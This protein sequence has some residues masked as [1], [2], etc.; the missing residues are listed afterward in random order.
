M[1]VLLSKTLISHADQGSPDNKYLH[2]KSLSLKC[3]I[4]LAGIP[5]RS[6][7]LPVSSPAQGPENSEVTANFLT[8]F[9][10]LSGVSKSRTL[11]SSRSLLLISQQP[12]QDFP[13]GAFRYLIH[14][15]DTTLDPLVRGFVFFYMLQDR[16]HNLSFRFACKRHCLDHKGLG[17]LARPVVRDLYNRTIGD[18]RM[19]EKMC[20]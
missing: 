17:D 10:L 2:S 9:R 1:Y 4:V 11:L 16:M 3:R 8:K 15:F 19:R 12:P 18:G 20:L 6:P 7:K 5:S 13:T 14:E